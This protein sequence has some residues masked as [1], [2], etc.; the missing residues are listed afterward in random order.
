MKF[1][2][3]IKKMFLE[4]EDD[5]EVKEAPREIKREEPREERPKVSEATL[6]EKDLYKSEPTFK[7]PV[8]FEEEVKPVVKE[9]RRPYPGLDRLKPKKKEEVEEKKFVASPVISPIYGILDK[10][11]KKEEITDRSE[12]PDQDPKRKYRKVDIDIIRQKAFGTLEEELEHTI[13]N[14]S[15]Y[16]Y[17]LADED[18]PVKKTNV[19]IE[20]AF[21]NYSDYGVEY[22]RT[23]TVTKEEPFQKTEVLND[24]LFDMINSAY[25]DEEEDDK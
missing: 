25:R 20:E 7:F 18:E 6:G 14:D 3:K 13:L 19:T 22:N 1:V 2:D 10:N 24:D 21:E 4:D 12:Q 17:G 5:N 11:Y 16:I 9:E 8:I 23:T 15:S